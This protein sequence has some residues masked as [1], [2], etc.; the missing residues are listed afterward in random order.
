MSLEMG[1]GGGESLATFKNIIKTVRVGYVKT[2][3]PL[4]DSSIIVFIYFIYYSYTWSKCTDFLK[5]KIFF[6]EHYQ[7]SNFFGKSVFGES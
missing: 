1:G 4:L 3:F 5:K 7:S 6:V 2:M